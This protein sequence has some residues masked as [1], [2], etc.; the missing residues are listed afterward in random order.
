MANE[1]NI[2]GLVRNSDLNTKFETL[3]TKA[4]LKADQDKI[5]EL[6]THDLSCFLD[7]NIFGDDG[8]QN[9]FPYWPMVDTFEL[10]KR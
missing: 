9:I 5:V 6:Q 1:S 2:S 8:F 3:A 7:K 10:K 4:E